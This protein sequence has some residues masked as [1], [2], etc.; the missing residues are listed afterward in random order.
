M[1]A[2]LGEARS[3]TWE[4]QGS[5]LELTFVRDPNGGINV[6]WPDGGWMGRVFPE[7]RDV[8]V[9]TLAGTLPR[10]DR[11]TVA[12]IVGK[13]RDELVDLAHGRP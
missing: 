13:H 5:R 10:A 11:D 2:K 8:H 6:L 12:A 9:K 4:A 3:G 7:Q 1:L